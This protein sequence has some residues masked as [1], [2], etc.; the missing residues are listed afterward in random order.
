[1]VVFGLTWGP[2]SCLPHS[3]YSFSAHSCFSALGNARGDLPVV[4]PRQ[5]CRHLRRLEL[6]QQLHHRAHHPAPCEEDGQ[7]RIHL[8]RGSSPS[9]P[10]LIDVF[11]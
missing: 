10:S 4:A 9:A 5:G 7:G 3:S 2:G 8:L 11:R 1:M 6:V